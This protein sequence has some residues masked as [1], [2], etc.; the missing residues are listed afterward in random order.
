VYEEQTHLDASKDPFSKPSPF[1]DRL[2]VGVRALE[3]WYAA[4]FERRITELSGLL[5]TQITEELRSQFTSELN[6]NAERIRKQHEERAYV[7]FKQW[8]SERQTLKTEVEELQ[9]RL[10]GPEL[11]NE[12]A[13][14]ETAI[15]KSLEECG[16]EAERRVTSAA[17]LTQLLQTRAQQLELHAYLRGL[18][19]AVS[20]QGQPQRAPVQEFSQNMPGFNPPPAIY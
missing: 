13:V 7:Q 5:R 20:Q 14:T 15:G 18:K 3:E 8:E 16:L 1:L 2:A 11:L 17:A 9:K 4:D 10:P 19:F 6:T 12:I